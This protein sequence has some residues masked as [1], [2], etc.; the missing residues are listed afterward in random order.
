LLVRRL[1]LRSQRVVALGLRGWVDSDCERRRHAGELE[2]ELFERRVQESF[3]SSMGRARER[4]ALV[5]SLM[6]GRC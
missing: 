3:S 4:A 5:K 1:A 2:L 6:L